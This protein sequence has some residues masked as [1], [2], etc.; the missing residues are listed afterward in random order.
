VTQ[1]ATNKMLERIAKALE[2]GVGISMAQLELTKQ[3]MAERKLLMEDTA[4]NEALIQS[5]LA[6]MEGKKDH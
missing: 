2:A 3:A 1:L 6:D 4:A 5:Y